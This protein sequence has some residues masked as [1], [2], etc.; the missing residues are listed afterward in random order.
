MPLDLRAI[1]RRSANCTTYKFGMADADRLAHRDVPDLLATIAAVVDVLDNWDV[2]TYEPTQGALV[3]AVR[4]ALGLTKSAGP[5]RAVGST[6]PHTSHAN[7]SE[8]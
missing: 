7:G 6:D 4:G 5:R 8:T 1:A 3:E 2:E